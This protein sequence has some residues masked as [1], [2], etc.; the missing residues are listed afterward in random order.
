M[1]GC[2]GFSQVLNKGRQL[3]VLQLMQV[4][5]P[6]FVVQ[7]LDFNLVR[8]FI[9]DLGDGLSCM[10][11]LVTN[12]GLRQYVIGINRQDTSLSGRKVRAARRPDPGRVIGMF[13]FSFFHYFDDTA[14]LLFCEYL[15]S[16]VK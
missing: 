11:E 8:A 16:T 6:A 3:N 13:V 15:L 10:G 14:R 9:D 5:Q 1:I 12:F 4:D 7:I 2:D